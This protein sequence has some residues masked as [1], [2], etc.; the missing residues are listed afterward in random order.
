MTPTAMLAD[1]ILPGDVF[2]ERNH[3]ADS[4]SWTTRLT[5]SQKVVEPPEQA[6]S[7]YQFWH[8]L[9]VRFGF[10]NEFPWQS[11][12]EVLDHRLA[13]SGRTFREFEEQGFME[14]PIPEYRKYRKTGFATPSGKVELY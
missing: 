11:I 13:R 7:T 2:T 5:L 4:W 8:D 12:E 1:Y 3:V 14:M 9:A 10:G 6:S